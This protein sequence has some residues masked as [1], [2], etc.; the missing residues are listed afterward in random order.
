MKIFTQIR[1]FFRKHFGDIVTLDEMCQINIAAPG[2]EIELG[3]GVRLKKSFTPSSCENCYFCNP[4]ICVK[5]WN[6]VIEFSPTS[7]E[8]LRKLNTIQGK[9]CQYRA[10]IEQKD[11]GEN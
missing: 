6:M 5:I 2:Q 10:L 4:R 11:Q 9:P 8:T 3:T 7:L 1:K